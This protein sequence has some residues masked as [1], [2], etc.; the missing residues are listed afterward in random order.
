M[1]N[2][3][4]MLSLPPQD[5]YAAMEWAMLDYGRRFTST[6]DAVIG[7][8][9]AEAMAGEWQKVHGYV[10]AGG[11]PVYK[12]PNCGLDEHVDVGG[13]RLMCEVCGCWNQYPYKR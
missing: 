6:P 4:Y 10:T 12:C 8:L 11:D 7:W 2:Q 1:T 3:E 5:C 9:G 13:R